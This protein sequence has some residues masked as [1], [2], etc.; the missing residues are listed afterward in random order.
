MSRPRPARRC[1]SSRPTLALSSG[2][3]QVDL[4]KDGTAMLRNFLYGVV[5]LTGSY[6]PTCRQDL[7]IDYIRRTVG[8]T[9]KVLC[10]DPT[11]FDLA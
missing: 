6:S 5:G 2:A 1:A 10:L 4:S 8:P 9:K 11:W 7:A 3:P